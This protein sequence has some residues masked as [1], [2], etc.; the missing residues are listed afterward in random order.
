[1]SGV[2]SLQLTTNRGQKCGG[3]SSVASRKNGEVMK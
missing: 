2:A 3:K 1:M